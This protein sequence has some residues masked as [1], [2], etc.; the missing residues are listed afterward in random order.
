MKRDQEKIK[1]ERQRRQKGKNE[2]MNEKEKL[3]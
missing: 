2:R 1:K 3:R